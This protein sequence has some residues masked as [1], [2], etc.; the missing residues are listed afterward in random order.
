MTKTLILGIG[1]TILSDEGAGVHVTIYLSKHF[2]N[3]S[4]ATYQDGG[5]LSFTLAEPKV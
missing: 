4:G 3:E 5:T 2:E 1:N